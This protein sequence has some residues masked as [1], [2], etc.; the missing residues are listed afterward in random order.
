MTL[1]GLQTQVRPDTS[2]FNV[3]TARWSTAVILTAFAPRGVWHMIGQAALQMREV[4][5]NIGGKAAPKADPCA[6]LVEPPNPMPSVT[7]EPASMRCKKRRTPRHRPSATPKVERLWL[8]DHETPPPS[9]PTPHD[10][11]GRLLRWVRSAGCSGKFVLAQDLQRIYPVM[12]TELAWARYPWQTVACYLRR[13]TGGRKIYKWVEGRRRRVYQIS[14][15]RHM[16]KTSH[17]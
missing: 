8:R 15:G 2:F 3:A 9:R 11:A 4:F 13:M 1:R 17:P 7:L 10:H 5:G 6:A 16:T 12:C 14:R